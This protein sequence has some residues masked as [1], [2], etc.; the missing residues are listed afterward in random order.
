MKNAEWRDEECSWIRPGMRVA[1]RLAA[2]KHM[3]PAKQSSPYLLPHGERRRLCERAYRAQQRDSSE[4][5]G[6][7]L[8]SAERVLHLHFLANRSERPASW[9]LYRS[10]IAA[11]RK[12]LQG[13]RFKVVGTFHSHPVSEAIPGTRDY[14]AMSVRSLQLIYDVCGCEVRL[15]TRSSKSSGTPKEL[16]LECQMR[17]K[18]QSAKSS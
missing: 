15:W 3:S 1:F 8:A 14:A 4:V 16:S 10:D 9:S 2:K 11:V 13:T 6:V 17:M 12:V 18:P 7:L 5:C